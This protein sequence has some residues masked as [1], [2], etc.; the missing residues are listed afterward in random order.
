M[1]RINEEKL[2][3]LSTTN[4]MLDEKYGVHGTET[5]DEFDEDSIA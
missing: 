5:R 4:H 1:R 3:K 2:S